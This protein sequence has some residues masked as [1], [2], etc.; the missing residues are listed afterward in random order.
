[1]RQRVAFWQVLAEDQQRVMR[2]SLP[3]E[4]LLVP[5]AENDLTDVVDVLI[6]NVFGHTPDGTPFDVTLVADAGWAYLVVADLG[7][8]IDLAGRTVRPGSTGLGLDI[9]RRLAVGCG[10]DLRITPGSDTA[11]G[12]RVEVVLPLVE[13]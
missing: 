3:A 1:V 13:R 6:D 12:T 10:G 4:A 11:A 2:V 7:P 9:V 8:G 5:V